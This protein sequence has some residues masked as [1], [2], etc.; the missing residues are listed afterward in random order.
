L[1]RAAS[2]LCLF[3]LAL[4]LLAPAPLA[5]AATGAQSR[6]PPARVRKKKKAKKAPAQVLTAP[7]PL[8]LRAVTAP[9][10]AP[11][12]VMNAPAASPSKVSTAPAATHV[13]GIV[14]LPEPATTNEPQAERALTA[15]P[16][17]IAP[18]AVVTV[19]FK[20]LAAQEANAAKAA[21]AGAV[22]LPTTLRAVHPPMTIRESGVRGAEAPMGGGG[23]VP[24][25]HAPSDAGGPLVPSPTPTQTFLAQEDG[26]KVGTTTFTIPPDTVGAVGLDKVFTQTNSNYRIH[27]KATGAPLSTVSMESF[28]APAGG[29]GVF[30]P[31]VVYDPY[32]NRWLL[33]AA[34]NAQTTS[35]SLLVGISDTSDPQ[36]AYHLY[37]FTMQAI[38]GSNANWADFPMLGFNKNWVAVSFNLFDN[39]FNDFTAGR[40][41]LLDYPAL[42]ANTVNAFATADI[43]ADNG[44]FCLYPATTLS[45]AESNLYMVAHLDSAAAAYRVIYL[46][47][48]NAS[49][50]ISASDIKTRAV[51]GQTGWTQPAGDILPQTC[52][53]VGLPCPAALRF[54]DV[55]DSFIRS[56]VVFRDGKIYYP[57]TVGIG[58]S[59]GAALTHT[60]AQWTVLDASTFEAVD[61]GA[62]KTR[63]RLARTV[64]AG[65]PTPP[66][67]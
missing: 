37:R 1:K 51:N 21:R 45:A 7:A 17:R 42:R 11:A 26:P 59:P 5:S 34:S 33:A 29:S 46:T 35:S 22:R 49:P 24:S 16:T 12:R 36:G 27:D 44:G 55:G 20:Q 61:G 30:D 66:S 56:N 43:T 31:K 40:V 52:G 14:R 13:P 18:N 6:K 47:G 53:P 62:S 9:A 38:T 15:T 25:F 4:A 64:V 28:W 58:A 8:P 10:P 60:A 57:Q 50:T 41:L 39:F 54:I 23:G 19:N 65:T 3:A 67:R 63:R 2:R 32:N 48:T